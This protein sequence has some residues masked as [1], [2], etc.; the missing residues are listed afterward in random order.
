MQL[1]SN[2][3]SNRLQGQYF[4]ELIDGMIRETAYTNPGRA[5]INLNVLFETK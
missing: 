4:S 5:D 2:T 3:T 1:R